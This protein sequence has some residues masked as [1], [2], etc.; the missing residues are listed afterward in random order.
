MTRLRLYLHP[1][2][3]AAQRRARRQQAIA[4]AIRRAGLHLRR[5]QDDLEGWR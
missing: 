4:A 1:M 2:R 3:A 5:P